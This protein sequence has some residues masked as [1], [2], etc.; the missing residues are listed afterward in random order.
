M[1]R[2][3]ND[4]IAFVVAVTAKIDAGKLSRIER[5]FVTPTPEE[6]DRL[7]AALTQM[8]EANSCV[9]KAAAEAGWIGAV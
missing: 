1:R 7:E 2:M 5:G 9:E 8:I 3:G 6:M 4:I